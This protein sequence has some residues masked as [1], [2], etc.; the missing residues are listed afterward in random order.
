M[1]KN[2]GLCLP[3][4]NEKRRKLVYLIVAGFILLFAI[5]YEKPL[6]IKISKD[7][8]VP[9]VKVKPVYGKTPNGHIYELG[10]IHDCDDM[11]C[12]ARTLEVSG[13]RNGFPT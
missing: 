2:E 8:D 4:I 5:I 12:P 9:E 1:G 13:S 11:N 6:E 7:E 10:T 3:L